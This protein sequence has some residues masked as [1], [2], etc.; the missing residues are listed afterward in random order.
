MKIFHQE[1]VFL[2]KTLI[3][4]EDIKEQ[5]SNRLSSDDVAS[6][7][8]DLKKG[9][10]AHDIIVSF[11]D[12][13]LTTIHPSSPSD[14]TAKIR[15]KCTS[16]NFCQTTNNIHPSALIILNIINGSPE[17]RLALQGDL[18]N[19]V[20]R[21]LC[22]F[23]VLSFRLSATNSSSDLCGLQADDYWKRCKETNKNFI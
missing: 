7:L 12:F 9:I 22:Q 3:D 5:E 1:L 8:E 16:S 10:K 18:D 19:A 11:Q 23:Y 15:E 13:L 21:H 17:D 6:L 20:Q 4:D 14:A 2:R